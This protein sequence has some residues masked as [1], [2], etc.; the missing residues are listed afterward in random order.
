MRQ[1]KSRGD[2]GHMG[3]AKRL[4]ACSGVVL[5]VVGFVA[6]RGAAVRRV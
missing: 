4:V 3:S 2:G 5:E 1:N 6:E